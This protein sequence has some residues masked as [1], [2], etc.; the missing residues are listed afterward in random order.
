MVILQCSGTAVHV[1]TIV[2]KLPMV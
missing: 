2:D 1:N